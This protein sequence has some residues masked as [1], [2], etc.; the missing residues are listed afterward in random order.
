MSQ[1]EIKYIRAVQMTE[2][3]INELNRLVGEEGYSVVE[4]RTSAIG[5]G[6]EIKLVRQRARIAETLETSRNFG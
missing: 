1:V 4:L 5:C 6:I 3:Q 2:A